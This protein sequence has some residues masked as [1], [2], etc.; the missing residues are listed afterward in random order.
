MPRTVPL[1]PHKIIGNF[2]VL[3]VSFVI[4]LIY[5][6]FVFVVWG[7]RIQGKPSLTL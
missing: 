6:V 4:L 5:Y 7:P 3:F 1:R 2:F